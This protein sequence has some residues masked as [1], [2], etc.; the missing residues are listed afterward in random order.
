MENDDN[1]ENDDNENYNYFDERN[2]GGSGFFKRRL[3]AVR[4]AT[5][6]VY[7]AINTV[8]NT[9]SHEVYGIKDEKP[10]LRRS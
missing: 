10:R 7:H 5:H 1:D 4:K 8:V 2:Y 3:R 9:R 6:S